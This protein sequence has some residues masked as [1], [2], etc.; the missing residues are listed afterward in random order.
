MLYGGRFC[1]IKMVSKQAKYHVRAV[2][3]HTTFIRNIFANEHFYFHIVH[4]DVK[5][6]AVIEMLQIS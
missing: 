6:K 2:K 3:K 1:K 4:A 5:H